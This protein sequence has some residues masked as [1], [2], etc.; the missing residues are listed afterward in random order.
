MKKIIAVLAILATVFSLSAC[1][2]K[3][4]MDADERAQYLAEKES[5]RI[6]QSLKV[7][8]DYINGIN[9]TVDEDIG[10]TEK[11]EKLVIKVNNPNAV[12]YQVYYF[13]RKEKFDYKL[14]YV[15][16]ELPANYNAIKDYDNDT[17]D[18]KLIK[19]NDEARMLVYKYTYKRDK[20]FDELYKNYK[21]PEVINLGYSIVE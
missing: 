7:E 18:K 13:D 10:K 19:H 9:E 21:M 2:M 6:E 16:Y 4:K 8:R 14:S 20:T 3:G 5:E 11:G 12:E 17:K 1:K 15:F